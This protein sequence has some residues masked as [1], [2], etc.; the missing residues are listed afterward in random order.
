MSIL[1]LAPVILLSSAHNEPPIFSYCTL[2]EL[3][4]VNP[5][6]Q[7]QNL[8]WGTSPHSSKSTLHSSAQ[9]EVTE[10]PRNEAFDY[11]I[12]PSRSTFHPSA[13]KP[14]WLQTFMAITH[15]LFSHSSLTPP[16]FDILGLCSAFRSC[17]TPPCRASFPSFL[18]VFL[19]CRRNS[20]PNRHQ[21]REWSAERGSIWAP[22]VDPRIGGFPNPSN[23]QGLKMKSK[24]A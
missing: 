4:L 15:N 21:E 13:A 7:N 20:L 19:S 17:L 1:H 14:V 24:E 3:E 9:V 16:R 5:H 23:G 8:R 6:L 22:I 2:P 10:K 12:T 11:G 18:L